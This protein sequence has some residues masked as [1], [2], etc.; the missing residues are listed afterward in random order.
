MRR[1]TEDDVAKVVAS[2]T[3]AFLIAGRGMFQR[4]STRC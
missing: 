4:C 3:V 2:V 1:G